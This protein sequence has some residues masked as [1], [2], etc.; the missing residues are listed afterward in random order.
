VRA[1]APA[2]QATPSLQPTAT[3][4]ERLADA[5]AVASTVAPRIDRGLNAPAPASAPASS[6]AP[7]WVAKPVAAPIITRG[8]SKPTDAQADSALTADDPAA[9]P[10]TTPEASEL[11]RESTDRFGAGTTYG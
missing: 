10:K 4:P 3:G 9:G 2:T 8:A 11:L 1:T 7:V 6:S 5:G